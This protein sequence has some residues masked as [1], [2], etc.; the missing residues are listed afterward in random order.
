MFLLRNR[1][2][3]LL[4][5]YAE[6]LQK[7]LKEK[8]IS[9]EIQIIIRFYVRRKYQKPWFSQPLFPPRFQGNIATFIG[10]IKG[11]YEKLKAQ[12]IYFR[13]VSLSWLYTM[14]LYIFLI[15]L[16]CNNNRKKREKERESES[17]HFYYKIPFYFD[18]VL[19]RKR[20]N[21][22]DESYQVLYI[23]PTAVFYFF[24]ISFLTHRKKPSHCIEL[25][26]IYIHFYHRGML[27]S[28]L[29]KP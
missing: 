29:I 6:K 16:M 18:V 11:K 2:L 3:K 25:L 20:E 15:Y 26:S 1:F 21:I 17:Y 12:N 19:G 5:D 13:A 14:R 28:T 24:W 10:V 22:W 7:N 8:S 27:V 23:S 9:K 4:F